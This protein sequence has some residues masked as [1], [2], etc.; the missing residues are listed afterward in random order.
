M[1]QVGLAILVTQFSYQ[2]V[3][4]IAAEADESRD[5]LPDNL[6]QWIYDIS[7]T[8]EQVRF[9]LYPACV[10]GAA[11]MAVIILLYIPKYV[12]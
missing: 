4:I 8:G 7:P 11:V 10:I 2:S 1:A 12:L 5:S 3:E 6:P 9:A